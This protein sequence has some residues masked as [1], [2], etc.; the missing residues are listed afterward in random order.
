MGWKNSFGQLIG[1]VLGVTIGVF[2]VNIALG[3]NRRQSNPENYQRFAEN[4]KIGVID[5]A[6]ANI[7]NNHS[8]QIV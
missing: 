6:V 5:Q 1:I 4:K 7:S 8:S 3:G 2:A